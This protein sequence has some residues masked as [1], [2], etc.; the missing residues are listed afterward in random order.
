MIIID[1]NIN[2]SQ[3]IL[4]IN[5]KIKIR[6]IG[7]E[8]EY[9]GISDKNI[10]SVL[11]KLR[12]P[13]FITR[14]DDFYNSKLCHQN[15]CLAYLRVEKNDSASFVRRFLKH[16]DFSSND[17]RVGKVI[18]VGYNSIKYYEFNKIGEVITKWK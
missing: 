1:E 14:D 13:T 16:Y 17:K 11:H 7:I 5:W 8:L 4:L 9:K 3:R 12:N 15:Y 2:Y 18:S 10:L 6:Q